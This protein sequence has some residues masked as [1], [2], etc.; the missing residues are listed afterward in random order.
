MQK[1]LNIEAIEHIT[2]DKIKNYI[3]YRSRDM[4]AIFRIENVINKFIIF[5]KIQKTSEFH[6]WNPSMV[7]YTRQ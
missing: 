4:L 7:F 3:A 1:D 6:I 2:E 5:T